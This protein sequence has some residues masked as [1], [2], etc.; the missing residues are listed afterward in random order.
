MSPSYVSLVERGLVNP[1]VASIKKIAAVL[2]ASVGSLVDGPEHIP[3]GVEA[4]VRRDRRKRVLCPGSDIRFELLSPDVHR[5]L[6]PLW[7]TAPIGADSG[8]CGYQHKGEECLVV[9]KGRIE[10]WLGDEKHVLEQG[11]SI[12]FDS[13]IPHRWLNSGDEVAEAVWVNT[14]P[15]FSD[16]RRG[17]VRPQNQT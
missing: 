15:T 12:Y 13:A 4:V 5:R 14:S 1:S 11:D 7:L 3:T 9:V 17:L 6:E 16:E 10:L 8:E 2:E